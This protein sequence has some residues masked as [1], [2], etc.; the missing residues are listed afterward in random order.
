MRH[1]EKLNGIKEILPNNIR[2]RSEC[3]K[4]MQISLRH[5]NTKR[6]VLLSESLSGSDGRDALHGLRRSSRVDEY[7]LVVFALTRC[8]QIVPNEFTQAELQ[9][10]SEER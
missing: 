9:Q 8:R 10:A 2:C 7:V 3:R 5:P 6:G 1:Y 4:R